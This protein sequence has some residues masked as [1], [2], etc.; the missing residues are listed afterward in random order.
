MIVICGSL[1]PECKQVGGSWGV[2][3]V[4]GSVED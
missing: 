1:L 3:E 4:C 2:G